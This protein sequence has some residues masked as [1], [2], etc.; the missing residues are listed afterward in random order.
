[1]RTKDFKLIVR[2]RDGRMICRYGIRTKNGI[3]YRKWRVS[4]RDKKLGVSRTQYAVFDETSYFE[5]K[6]VVL[7]KGRKP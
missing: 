4:R 2:L 5:L 3:E 1:M 7:H 6:P